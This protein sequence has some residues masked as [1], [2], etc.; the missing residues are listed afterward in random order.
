M[1]TEY[2]WKDVNTGEELG[3]NPGGCLTL[4]VLGLPVTMALP[5]TQK[6][7]SCLGPTHGFLFQADPPSLAFFSGPSTPPLTQPFDPILQPI[8]GAS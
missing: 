4:P 2:F 3:G 1:E 6:W 8:T 5:L 7:G